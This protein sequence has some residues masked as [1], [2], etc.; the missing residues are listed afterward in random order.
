MLKDQIIEL[1]NKQTYKG[2]NVKEL[3]REV[4]CEDSASFTSLMKVLNELE[5]DHVVARDDRDR[6]FLSSRLGYI[7]NEF[8]RIWVCRGWR[9]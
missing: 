4:Q 7:K 3:S 6:Y 2:M 5:H 1:L 8:K 9:K